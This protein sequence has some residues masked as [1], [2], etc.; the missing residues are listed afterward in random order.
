LPD[1]QVRTD[2]STL[3]LNRVL[4]VCLIVLAS[5]YIA[6]SKETGELRHH[7]PSES[8]EGTLVIDVLAVGQG[9]S[10]FIR[11]PSG[12]TILIDG[13]NP[14]HGAR[15]VLPTIERCFKIK[16]LDYVIL[17]HPH[18][19]HF[20]GLID[21]LK[22]ISVN[23]AIYDTGGSDGVS[24]ARYST[25]ADA[26]GKRHIPALGENTLVTGDAVKIKIV[27]ENGHVLGGKTISVF[28]ADSSPKDKNSVS[29]AMV[30]SFGNFRYF[31]GGDLS[32]GGSNTPDVE[33][34][35]ADVV[36]PVDLMK[37][38]HHG[39][40]TANNSHLLDKLR[41][42]NILIS[43]G[44]GKANRRYHLPNANTVVRFVKAPFIENIYETSR[45]EGRI[46]PVDLTKVHD[47]N[48]DIVVIASPDTYSIN[49]HKYQALPK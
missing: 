40:A 23:K 42:H 11:T 2:S 37:A 3:S 39:S 18:A 14:G 4:I 5:P 34:A 1:K 15:D 28:N 26:T 38:D 30:L 10:T 29:I 13:G 46:P 21:V 12:T 33:S 43:V 49:D 47:E 19:D 45:G 22:K 25:L 24:F 7:C 27:A 48:G 6:F 8:Y 36:G 35:V 17:T 41:P 32:G 9:D 44:I 16:S 20:G 31:T